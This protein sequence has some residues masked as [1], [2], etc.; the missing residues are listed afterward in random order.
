M[1]MKFRLSLEDDKE[2]TVAVRRGSTSQKEEA[3]QAKV[4]KWQRKEVV[5][6]WN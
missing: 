5:S 4:L 6:S 1:D 2:P 3:R